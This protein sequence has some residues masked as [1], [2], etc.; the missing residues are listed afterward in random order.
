MPALM[1]SVTLK[2]PISRSSN[3]IWP[4]SGRRCALI[5]LTS[6][7]LPAPFEPT[8]DRNSPLLTTKF[9]PS[10]RRVSP[11]FFLSSTVLSRATRSSLCRQGC[12][13]SQERD[14]RARHDQG[15]PDPRQERLVGRQSGRWC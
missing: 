11:N 13:S 9:T 4:E 5:R 1:R 2:G 3:R 7:V 14:Y 8:S 6:E 10:P 12:G 15:E